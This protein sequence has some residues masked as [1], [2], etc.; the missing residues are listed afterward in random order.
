MKSEFIDV[1]IS[2]HKAAISTRKL[3]FLCRNESCR[4]GEKNNKK[5]R[6]ENEAKFMPMAHTSKI[7]H[8][9]LIVTHKSTSQ[10]G[11]SITR[12][13]EICSIPK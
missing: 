3:C 13:S 6:K 2:Y 9:I 10:H 5:K 8:K 12:K 7:N 11:K 4:T 1:G